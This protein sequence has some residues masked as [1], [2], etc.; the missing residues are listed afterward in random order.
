MPWTHVDCANCDW[1]RVAADLPGSQWHPTACG[2][3]TAED[4]D[5]LSITARRI[6]EE[7]ER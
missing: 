7:T 4:I 1:C 2:R 6:Y 3:M 5:R